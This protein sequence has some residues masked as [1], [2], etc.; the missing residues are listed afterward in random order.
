MFNL[1]L[2]LETL[3]DIELCH[4]SL[5]Q[6][7]NLRDILLAHLSEVGRSCVGRKSESSDHPRDGI[8]SSN[9]SEANINEFDRVEGSMV[10][11]VGWYESRMDQALFG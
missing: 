5:H 6:V 2:G 10:V 4:V 8:S 9:G 11:T 3:F 7:E 1:F